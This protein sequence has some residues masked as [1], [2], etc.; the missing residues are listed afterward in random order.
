MEVHTRASVHV[1]ILLPAES[2]NPTINGAA[3]EIVTDV[4]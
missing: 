4:W 2:G 3:N 1:H